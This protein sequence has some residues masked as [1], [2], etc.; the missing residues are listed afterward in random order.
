MPRLL[1]T[2]QSV[3]LLDGDTVSLSTNFLDSVGVYESPSRDS[4]SLMYGRDM[5]RGLVLFFHSDKL[6]VP[7]DLGR[8]KICYVKEL[9]LLGPGLRFEAALREECNHWLSTAEENGYSCCD[10]KPNPEIKVKLTKFSTV[11]CDIPP[12]QTFTESAKTVSRVVQTSSTPVKSSGVQ[13]TALAVPINAPETSLDCLTLLV[14]RAERAE[15]AELANGNPSKALN[16]L[17]NHRVGVDG[18]DG[19]RGRK[20]FY[21]ADSEEYSEGIYPPT[22]LVTNSD[23]SSD[24]YCAAADDDRGS[25]SPVKRKLTQSAEIIRLNKQVLNDMAA[26]PVASIEAISDVVLGPKDISGVSDF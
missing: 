6:F 22:P 21:D 24:D 4:Y 7:C 14:P 1:G 11:Q 13:T 26:P 19:G 5:L 3:Q 12:V 10:R 9:Q 17:G 25:S 16:G 8:C 20:Q 15:R 23:N 2:K 18:M